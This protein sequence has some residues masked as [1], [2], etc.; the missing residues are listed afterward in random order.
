M[1]TDLPSINVVELVFD[2]RHADFK[3]IFNEFLYIDCNNKNLT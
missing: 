2:I 1:L 3:N